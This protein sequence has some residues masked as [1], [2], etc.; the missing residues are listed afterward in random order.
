[1][2]TEPQG[3]PVVLGSTPLLPPKPLR[4]GQWLKKSGHRWKLLVGSFLYMAPTVLLLGFI[5]SSRFT[6]AEE[7]R[8]I[9]SALSNALLLSVPAAAVGVALRQLIRCRVCGLHLP[10][11]VEARVAGASKWM[12]V[13]S[14]GECPGCGDDGT[15]S[16]ESRARWKQSGRVPEEPYWSSSRIL[17]ALGIVVFGMVAATYLMDFTASRAFPKPKPSVSAV[18]PK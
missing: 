1:M 13:A 17:L 15:A 14:L 11:S 9:R 4:A 6:R 16:A 8:W 7:H 12:W 2:T 3:T 5:F 18:S 10:S